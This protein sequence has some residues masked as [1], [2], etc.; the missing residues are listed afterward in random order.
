MSKQTV[1]ITG[2][3]RGI[4]KAIGQTMLQ[5]GYHVIGTARNPE[6]VKDKLEGATY[7]PLDLSNEQSVEELYEHI[8]DTRIDILVNNAGQSQLGPVEE[9]DMEKYR[10]LFEVNFFGLLKLTKYILPQMRERKSGTIINIGSLTGRFALPYYSSY[11]ATKF[12]LSGF[13]QSLRSEMMDFG[14]KVVLIEPNDIGTSIVPEFLC[15]NEAEYYP[16]ANKVREKVKANM[17][18]AESPQIIVNAVVN[19]IEKRDTK[20]VYVAGGNAGL[21]KFVKR[22]LPDKL[23]E[24]IIRNSYDL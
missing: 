14:V 9:S 17:A 8:K 1:L 23:A 12:A 19:A 18:H 16:M 2:M 4:G 22:L 24:K 5:K 7:L 21:L 11:C 10:Y 15:R 13:T 20:P 3:S 6:T